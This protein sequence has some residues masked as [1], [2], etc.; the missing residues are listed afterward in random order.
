MIMH[1]V[2]TWHLRMAVTFVNILNWHQP[3]QFVEEEAEHLLKEDGE[4]QAKHQLISQGHH[5]IPQQWW[6]Q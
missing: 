5:G 1:K 6:Q 4:D 2:T 3:K